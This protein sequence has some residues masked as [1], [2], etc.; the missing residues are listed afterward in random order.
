L[1]YS[2]DKSLQTEASI[3]MDVTKKDDSTCS[4]IKLYKKY[5]STY[6]II[7]MG[8]KHA[9]DRIIFKSS[10]QTEALLKIIKK[11]SGNGYMTN[12]NTSLEIGSIS[13]T[14]PQHLSYQ[15]NA[16]F[17]DSVDRV[18][19]LN[20]DDKQVCVPVNKISQNSNSLF[21]VPITEEEVLKA[22]IK[23]KGK[24]SAGYDEIPAMLIEHCIQFINK[25]LTFIFYLSLCSGTFP[26]VTK[27]AKVGPVFK[28][29]QKQDI[30]NYRPISIL[31]AF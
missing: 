13:V 28:K 24:Y 21:V 27:I 19:N 20:N 23:L 9:N 18:L 8:R 25:Q 7:S 14:S 30:L 11:E 22:T 17:V 4:N 1:D 6:K 16:Y 3:V 29:D 10:D 26:C 15:F 2:R 5:Q 12:Q 31:P